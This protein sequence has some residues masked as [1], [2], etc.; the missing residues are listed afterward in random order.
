MDIYLWFSTQKED[1]LLLY[2]LAIVVSPNER[3]DR[4]QLLATL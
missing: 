3:F 2:R 1:Y 4:S